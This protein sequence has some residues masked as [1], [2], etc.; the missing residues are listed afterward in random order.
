MQF[1]YNNLLKKYL[2]LILIIGIISLFFPAPTF[3]ADSFT[4]KSKTASFIYN[5][6]GFPFSVQAVCY[7]GVYGGF[8]GHT[9]QI[10]EYDVSGA[11]VNAGS[12]LISMNMIHS[13][14][15]IYTGSTQKAT[16]Y[17]SDLTYFDI[18]VP[19]N[20]Q[21]WGDYGLKNPCNLFLN[22][23]DTCQSVVSAWWRSDDAFPTE[24]TP[25]YTHIFWNGSWVN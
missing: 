7:V 20:W 10:D 2:L 19:S 12:Y 18:L 21:E 16:Y 24:W 4:S 13:N 17:N 11:I 15:K 5:A 1:A 22:T 6:T 25:T 14:S 9:L 3:A 23:T 8:Y